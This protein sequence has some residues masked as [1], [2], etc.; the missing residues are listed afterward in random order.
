MDAEKSAVFEGIQWYRSEEKP[1]DFF[2]VPGDPEPE[3][4]PDGE[5]TLSVWV[6]DRGS[7]L[8]LGARWGVDAERLE[9]LRAFLAEQFPDLEPALIRLLPT[10]ASIE[11][12][13]LFLVD[14]N[15]GP[16]ELKTVPSSGFPPYSALFHVS[17][18]AEDTPRVVAAV[19]GR[20]DVL[21]VCYRGSISKETFVEVSIEGEVGE[22]L[23]ALGA[24]P[25]PADC[26]SWIETALAEGRLNWRRSGS[27]DVAEE[28]WNKAERL[29][30]EK[31]AL[32]LGRLAQEADPS[33]PRAGDVVLDSTMLR[34]SAAVRERVP[35]PST[36]VTDVA[37][38]FP[39]AAAANHIHVLPG[40]ATATPAHLAGPS[41]AQPVRLGF[42]TENA[43]IAF[44]Q[45]GRGEASATFRA[46]TFEP[47]ALPTGVGPFVVKTQY[48]SGGPPYET[49][50]AE[51]VLAPH[52]L[53]LARVMV[54]GSRLRKAG[55]QEARVR[56]RYRPSGGGAEDDRTVYL[57]GEKWMESW[58]VVTRAA[59]LNGRLEFEWKET[60][61][62]G[63]VIRHSLSKADAPQ[64]RL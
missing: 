50:A 19:N 51:S 37:K 62:D 34:A 48:S 5:P 12:V 58:F 16:R 47:I 1:S 42:E 20:K 27:Q 31:A 22:G 53:G 61:A 64:I 36:R 4:G 46:P 29:A 17:L 8:Q 30:R 9:R 14:D 10:P 33:R 55:A 23:A 40:A 7:T 52:D 3:R 32:A 41:G 39:A 45:V 54:D 38:W 25:S 2:F 49:N 11:S 59:D 60:T 6:S 21:T 26:R 13:G 18:T 35:I 44:V 56:V 28:L 15:E 63:S 24:N 43:P 57:R